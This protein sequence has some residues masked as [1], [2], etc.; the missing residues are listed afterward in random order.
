MPELDGTSVVAQ[1]IAQCV[2]C[3]CF[4][5]TRNPVDL[6]NEEPRSKIVFA[7]D[8]D[9]YP[10]TFKGHLYPPSPSK[11]P[12]AYKFLNSGLYLGR[13]RD[14]QYHLAM[15]LLQQGKLMDDP[16]FSDHRMFGD[17][18]LAG[19]YSPGNAPSIELDYAGRYFQVFDT[20]QTACWKQDVHSK[21]VRCDRMFS[22]EA[23][24]LHTAGH[25]DFFY[26]KLVP[27]WLANETDLY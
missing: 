11:A 3:R 20:R 18:F 14:I 16:K 24:M 19:L 12:E 17:I 21:Q 8:P 27:R 15:H 1:Q 2:S 23:C 7:T 4:P 9:C 25:K 5:C 22:E 26:Q 6:F 10:D 13:V